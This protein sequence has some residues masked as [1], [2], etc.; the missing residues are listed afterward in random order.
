MERIHEA[1]NLPSRVLE[2]NPSLVTLK[3]VME[4]DGPHERKLLFLSTSMRVN[5]EIVRRQERA[6]EMIKQSGVPFEIIDGSNPQMK[7]QR[8]EL[9][10]ISGRRGVY[11][12]FYIY[13][14]EFVDE[15]EEMVHFIGDWDHIEAI[16]DASGLPQET[17]AAHPTIKTWQTILGNRFVEGVGSGAGNL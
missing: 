2:E 7:K 6:T 3:R 14:T 17:L 9:F 10:K 16:N 13:D 8:D 12:Q 5:P 1:D 15:D 11:P 4:V